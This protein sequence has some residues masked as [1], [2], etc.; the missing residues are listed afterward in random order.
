[1][2]KLLL[3]G[4]N[5]LSQ[6]GNAHMMRA[7]ISQLDAEQYR[8][9]C[10]GSNFVRPWAIDLF[11]KPME[12][13]FIQAEIGSSDAEN[14]INILNNV[15]IDALVMVGIDIWKYAAVF[16][17]ITNAKNAKGFKWI[18]I[19]PYDLPDLRQ[20]WVKWIKHIDFPCVYSRHGE[21]MLQGHVP[22]IR[23]FRPPLELAETYHPYE[24]SKRMEVRRRLFP[25]LRDDQFLFGFIGANQYRKDPLGL[26]DAF[27]LV[28]EEIPDAVL[29]LHTELDGVIN[30]NQA[31]KDCGFKTADILIK[32]QGVR[33]GFAH[34]I[35]LY[36]SFDCF[37]NCSIQEG[38]S[39]TVLEAMLC[40][41]PVIASDTTAHPELV[42]GAGLLVPCEE[43]THMPL[44][45]EKGAAWIKA[46]RC[47][48]SDIAGMMLTMARDEN[49]IRATASSAGIAQGQEW[50]AGV[51]N[52]NDLLK[53]VFTVPVK[54]VEAK[55]AKILFAQ[56]SSAGDVLMSTQCFKGVKERHPGMP[57]VFMT[58][59]QYQDI[60]TGNPYV[61]E[62]IDWDPANLDRYE[63]LYNPHG[64]KILPGGWNN[65]DVKLADMYPYFCKVEADEMFIQEVK[66]V[67]SDP[68]AKRPYSMPPG[69]RWRGVRELPDEYIVVHTTG[70][71]AEYRGYKHMDLALKGIDLPIVQIGGAPDLVCQSAD[72]DLRGKLSWRETAWIMKRAE[73]AV[74]IDSFPAHLAGAVGTPVVALFGPAPSRVTGPIGKGK[75]VCLEPK[76]LDVCKITSHCWGNPPPDKEKCMSPC[77]NTISPLE[78]RKALKSLLEE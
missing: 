50:L 73:A 42:D 10:F 16:G 9:A 48:P 14:L 63:I 18:S 24:E 70:G 40:G 15:D 72:I 64:E 57:L 37:V 11:A 75:I 23:Y 38:L 22:G 39:W 3:V 66:P 1:M 6:T 26:L 77:I 69:V 4:E 20:D 8:I 56:H 61:D 30:L 55:I 27:V 74:A 71:S 29:Y 21:S 62:I 33:S 58:L 32:P 19:F 52:I 12:F 54:T 13:Q 60:V 43:P 36:N 51:S 41:T 67:I 68:D 47:R 35:D 7:I 31:L 5:P 34:M 28:K 44:Y 46:K 2:K 25:Q 78:V 59:P 65:L 49:D 53:E 17:H 45:G 76:M